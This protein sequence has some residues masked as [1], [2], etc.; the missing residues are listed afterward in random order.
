MRNKQERLSIAFKEMCRLSVF[1]YLK[2][3][4]QHKKLAELNSKIAKGSNFKSESNECDVKGRTECPVFYLSRLIKKG[5]AAPLFHN[6]SQPFKF[7][8]VYLYSLFSC[9]SFSC[10]L[11]C[12]KSRNN[13]F[14]LIVGTGSYICLVNLE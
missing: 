7:F 4:K 13:L 9:F 2:N 6:S 5:L 11:F 14:Q 3:A 8:I 1:N 10:I 12:I